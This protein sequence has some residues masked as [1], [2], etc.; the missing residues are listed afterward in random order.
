MLTRL[1]GACSAMFLLTACTSAAMQEYEVAG[2]IWYQT[3]VNPVTDENMRAL[4]KQGC[5]NNPAETKK[6]G[7]VILD[8][9]YLIVTPK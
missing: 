2:K 5:R 8:C 3:E 6:Q 9:P 4:A 1:A 7:R